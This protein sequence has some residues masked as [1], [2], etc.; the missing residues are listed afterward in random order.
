MKKTVCFL[1]SLCLCLSLLPVFAEESYDSDEI[2][3]GRPGFDL[4]EL[5]TRTIT[6]AMTPT[7]KVEN[8]DGVFT[9]TTQSGVKITL[10]TA[11]LSYYTFT[12]DFYASLDAYFRLTDEAGEKLMDNMIKEN[13]HFFI[14]DV[15][16]SFF[17]EMATLG[18]DRLSQHVQ[19]LASLS[20]S[21]L[22][23]VAGRIAEGL[24]DATEYKLL[25]VNGN[26]WIRVADRVFVTIVN[27]EYH[28]ATYFPAG[29]EMTPDDVLDAEAFINALKLE[30]PAAE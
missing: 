3:V 7:D 5:K 28:Y 21:A 18:S 20:E 9:V 12:Q 27:G 26:V 23:T 2:G 16:D 8:K 4:P 30:A 6:S 19:D 17:I 15:Y 10:N 14:R 25:T 11:G 24:L 22:Q 29:E 13:C 1:L